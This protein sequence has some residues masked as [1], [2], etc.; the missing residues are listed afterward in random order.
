[1]TLFCVLSLALGQGLGPPPASLGL[2]SFYRKH[3]DLEGLPIVSSENVPDAALIEAHRMAREMLRRIPEVRKRLIRNQIRIAIMA[4]REQTL[5]I[6]EHADL[7][8]AFP[9][10][11][12]NRRARGLGA[13]RERPAISAAE[14]NL[15]GYYN[16][17]YR[18]ESIF[19]HEFAHTIFDLGL[20]EI[21]VRAVSELDRAFRNARWNGLWRRTYAA[22]NPSE[23]WAEGVQSYFN[24]N[25]TA[26]PPNGIHNGIG[27][28]DALKAYD[29]KLFELIDGVFRTSW[30]WKGPP[31]DKLRT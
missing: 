30:T 16:D 9:Q 25:R 6:P 5:D 11:D 12:W 1:M 29:P 26:S 14:E 10:T 23:Y 8:R 21:N 27:T 20:S 22:T 4:E 15:L 18:G 19:I 3:V 7:Q 17:R 31:S 13:T 24:A 2:N 28:R